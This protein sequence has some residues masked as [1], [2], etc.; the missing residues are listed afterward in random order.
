MSKSMPVATKLILSKHFPP[1]MSEFKFGR[2]QIQPVPL[3]S[4]TEVEVILSFINTY[5]DPTGGGS[6]PEEEAN[7]ICRLL[8]VFLDSRIKKNGLRINEIDI[9]AIVSQD[10]SQYSQFFGVFD[11]THLE[12]YLQRTL[13]L[14]EDLARQFIRACHTYSFALEFIPSD[15]TFAFFLLVVTGECMSSQDK[16]IPFSDLNPACKSCERFCRFITTFLLEEFKGDD[17]KNNE[18]FIELLKT[19][20]YSHRSGFVHGGKEVSSAA[21]M[22]DKTGSSYFKHAT[23]G[24]EVRTPGLGWFAK[25]I[26]GAI[27]GYIGSFPSPSIESV[28]EELFSRLAFEKAC[29]KIKSKRDVK[30][31]HVVTS[32]DIEYR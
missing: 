31:G 16:V 32:E 2:Y 28:D 7:I 12:N 25:I 6:H 4:T 29:L 13:S 26:R 5:K 15:P 14:D 1:G 9:P 24:K 21:L 11:P 3:S 10:N 23:E 18:L 22:A 27:L 8:S 30:K 19:V 17:E 20:Y